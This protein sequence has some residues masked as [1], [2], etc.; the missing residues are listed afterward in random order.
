MEIRRPRGDLC[1]DL[2]GEAMT[3]ASRWWQTPVVFAAMLVCSVSVAGAQQGT[4]GGVVKDETSGNPIVAARVEAVGTAI[5][6]QTNASGH[7]V[8]AGLSPGQV[9]LRV[10][11]IG[12]GAVRS[13]ERR[14]GKECRSRG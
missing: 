9:T 13:E 4:V 7:Y 14:V 5:F 11:A 10:S 3:N 1:H 2:R 8:L 12:Y 6:G